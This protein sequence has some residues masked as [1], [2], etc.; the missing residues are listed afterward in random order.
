MAPIVSLYSRGW[1]RP[2]AGGGVAVVKATFRGAHHRNGGKMS[3]MWRNMHLAVVNE[4]VG[5]NRAATGVRV[6][7]A[8]V[9]LVISRHEMAAKLVGRI[10]DGM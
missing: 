9:A 10:G 6:A 5:E 4:L 2:G 7:G 8:L 3:R 1:A